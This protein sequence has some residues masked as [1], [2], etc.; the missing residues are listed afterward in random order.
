MKRASDAG[1]QLEPVRWHAA[2]RRAA[3]DAAS[4]RTLDESMRL[5]SKALAQLP[6]AFVRSSTQSAWRR[7][8]V[9]TRRIAGTAIASTAFRGCS[10]QGFPSETNTSL[11]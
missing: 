5:C 1:G 7:R 10:P 6:Q 4:L 9:G 11:R 3:A 8:S 2:V